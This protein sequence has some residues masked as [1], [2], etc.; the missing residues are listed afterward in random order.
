MTGQPHERAE[1]YNA[2]T[3]A[4]TVTVTVQGAKRHGTADGRARKVAERLA[5]AAARI[6]GVVEV[7]ATAGPTVNGEVTRPERVR[8]AQANSG[9]GTYAEPGKLDRYLDPEHERAV[10]SLCAEN[11]AAEK[12]RQADR[13]RRRNTGCTN[14]YALGPTDWRYCACVYCQPDEHLLAAQAAEEDRPSPFCNHRC[15]CGTPVPAAGQRCLSHRRVEIVVLD[16]DPDALQQLA[17]QQQRL[18][19]TYQPEQRPQHDAELEL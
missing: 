8:F 10:Q 13:D 1:F 18:Q 6:P 16:A 19:T 14:T 11:A 3:Y 2:V 7:S 4:V 9:Q 15:V 12:R 17:E 5:N